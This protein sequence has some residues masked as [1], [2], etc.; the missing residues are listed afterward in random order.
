MV[1]SDEIAYGHHHP[2]FAIFPGSSETNF[3][4]AKS[5]SRVPSPVLGLEC[6]ST[7]MEVAQD[8]S[9][10]DADEETTQT[11]EGGIEAEEDEEKAKKK[12]GEDAC[13]HDGK[14]DFQRQQRGKAC[15]TKSSL[16]S[17]V[18]RHERGKSKRAKRRRRKSVENDADPANGNDGEDKASKSNGEAV[19]NDDHDILNGGDV[20]INDNSATTTTII[21]GIKQFQC[22]HCDKMMKSR[23]CLESHIKRIHGEKKYQC[24]QCGLKYGLQSQL[25][26]HM[27]R[28]HEGGN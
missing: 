5:T 14:D 4:D 27:K 6:D 21:S 11:D 23:G 25:N 24:G 13:L 10:G 1:D 20:V 8:V 26:V 9:D 3:A 18:R 12:N 15:R 7:T 17:H 16:N 22:P 2:S 19:I 28:D